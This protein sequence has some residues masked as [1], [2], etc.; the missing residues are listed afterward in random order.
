[1][2]YGTEGG[3]GADAGDAANRWGGD[4]DDGLERRLRRQGGGNGAAG[5]SGSTERFNTAELREALGAQFQ[6]PSPSDPERTP[7]GHLDLRP[8]RDLDALGISYGLVLDLALKRAL[9]DGRTSTTGLAS[10][11][12][13]SPIIVDKIVEELRQLRYV[14]IQGLE[15]RDY[16]LGLTEAGRDQA[17]ARASISRYA[18]A[19]PVTL[20]DYR[21]VV[22]K[23]IAEPRINREVMR[24]AFSD[25]VVG[26]RLLDELGPAV[27]SR[28]AMFLY[29]PPGTGK[30]SI[31]ERLNR[32]TKDLV[33]I[34]RAVEIDGQ[35]IAVFDPIVHEAADPQ[36]RDLDP[37]WVLCK[38]PAIIAGGE[39]TAK[40][41]DLIWE[42]NSGLYLAPLQMQAN[43]GVLVIDDFGRQK[44]TP[45]ELLNRWIV[46]LDR[47]ID[48]LSLGGTKFEVPFE[49]KVVLSTN[50]E[51][52]SLGDEAFF[53]RI[54]NKIFVKPVDDA[55]FDEVLDR[56]AKAMGILLTEDSAPYLRLTCREFGD[57]DLRP[58]VPGEFCKLLRAVCEY[59]QE[60][61]VLTREN[62]DDIASIFFTQPSVSPTQSWGHA[63]RLPTIQGVGGGRSS[64]FS[65]PAP[66]EDDSDA[67]TVDGAETEQLREP[68]AVG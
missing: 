41:L 68:E 47:R 56:C 23:Q 46:P 4:D 25:L 34:P 31:A 30:T 44:M 16:I 5:G 10:A 6:P 65:A 43:N 20:D 9:Q 26:E 19:C 64:L 13:L 39:L 22:M 7:E 2:A 53:R 61:L 12:A 33:L 3:R 63:D 21:D 29:G 14:E 50:L 36:P 51:P 15:G 45:T 57:G 24:S 62:I 32:I 8:P 40:Q 1:M 55:E 27:I 67:D 54:Q 42:P 66:T 60:A 58:Y 18:G 59:K 49:T 35:V 11:L 48:F 17:T 52:S 38:R 37:R 28:G